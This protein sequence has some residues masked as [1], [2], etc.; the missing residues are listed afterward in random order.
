V[1]RKVA[2]LIFVRVCPPAHSRL[3]IATGFVML[4]CDCNRISQTSLKGTTV[5]PNSDSTESKPEI[6]YPCPWE[7][8]I[9]GRNAD[10]MR[11][12]VAEVMAGREH[13]L[14]PSNTSRTGK[15]QSMQLATT[16]ADQPERDAIFSAL[17]NHGD[18]LMVL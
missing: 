4:G 6:V 10:S 12:A 13:T 16:V 8:K 1:A 17:Q 2:G 14:T 7:Y 18:I 3:T 15:Y 11:A 5:D 9:V